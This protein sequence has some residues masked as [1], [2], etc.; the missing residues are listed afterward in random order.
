MERGFKKINLRLIDNI[1]K[2]SLIEIIIIKIIPRR[3][4]RGKRLQGMGREEALKIQE[5]LQ[6][7]YACNNCIYNTARTFVVLCGVHTKTFGHW[8]S[9]VRL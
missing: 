8:P 2:V 1:R 6:N 3:T 5:Y 9:R 7:R 4:P